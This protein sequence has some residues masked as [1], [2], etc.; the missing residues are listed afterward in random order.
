MRLPWDEIQSNAVS[1]SKRWEKA[2]RE[3]ADEQPFIIEL[4]GVFGVEDPYRM[5]VQEERATEI[6]KLYTMEGDLNVD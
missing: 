4:L 3:K 1:F 6:L 2:R 5:E